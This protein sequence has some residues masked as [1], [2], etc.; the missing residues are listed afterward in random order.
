MTDISDI[1]F[2]GIDPGIHGAVAF[3]H[4]IESRGLPDVY[5][6]DMP[7]GRKELCDFFTAQC[8]VPPMH[9][10][11]AGIENPQ[12]VP[13]QRARSVATFWEGIGIIKGI[14]LMLGVQVQ[15][16][17]PQDWKTELG[18]RSNSTKQ[19]KALSIARARE[20]FSW[21]DLKDKRDAGRSDALLIAE[22]TRRMYGR[23]AAGKAAARAEGS[24]SNK[25]R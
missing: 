9:T 1:S 6:V 16:V 12:P 15:A 25:R 11:V 19:A 4:C 17:R 24:L 14:L 18:T 10:F 13:L 5:V 8:F 2:I 22:Y 3:I 7:E 23:T 20:L 21:V